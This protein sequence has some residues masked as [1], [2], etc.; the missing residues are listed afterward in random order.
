MT[1]HN[2]SRSVDKLS[3][4]FTFFIHSKMSS[5][6]YRVA[7]ISLA[8]FGRKEVIISFLMLSC[9]S[10]S[11]SFQFV[12]PSDVSIFN[13]FWTYATSPLLAFDVS[14]CF[15]LYL[16]LL[17]RYIIHSLWH[18]CSCCVNNF[19]ISCTFR[20]ELISWLRLYMNCV[21]VL[22]YHCVFL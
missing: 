14:E 8:D 12:V 11:F 17:C 15:F 6:D 3:Q 9:I 22:M 10:Y 20:C 4:F 7:D 1:W 13:Y 21:S 5:G 16:W 19:Y 2:L 18:N